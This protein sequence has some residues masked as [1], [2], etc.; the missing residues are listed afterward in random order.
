MEIASGLI[1][2]RQGFDSNVEYWQQTMSTRIDEVMQSLQAEGVQIESWF[3]V[4]IEG[5]DY[6]IWY[7][8]AESIERAVEVFQQSSKDID[9]FHFEVLSQITAPDGFINAEPLLDF[10]H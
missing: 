8:R 6:L 3:K 4:K 10:H 1:K 2:L 7:M 9:K 5:D